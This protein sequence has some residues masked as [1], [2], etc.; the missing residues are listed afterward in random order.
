M[1]RVNYPSPEGILKNPSGRNRPVFARGCG[2]G[3]QGGRQKFFAP[4]T[5]PAYSI[6]YVVAT[7][8]RERGLSLGPLHTLLTKFG[9]GRCPASLQPPEH[10]NII[11]DDSHAEAGA[12]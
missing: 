10:S 2:G 1:M 9:S 4:P 11:R 6:E 7:L 12:Q 3:L 5:A 8:G